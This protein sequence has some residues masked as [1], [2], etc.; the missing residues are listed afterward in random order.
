MCALK[1]VFTLQTVL[2]LPFFI[3]NIVILIFVGMFWFD[4]VTL[5]WSIL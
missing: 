5:Q 1:R 4:D 2:S 3:L